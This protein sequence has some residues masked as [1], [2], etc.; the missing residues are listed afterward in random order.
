MTFFS[1]MME[2]AT[3]AIVISVLLIMMAVVMVLAL[4]AGII[5]L[6]FGA[7]STKQLFCDNPIKVS[8]NTLCNCTKHNSDHACMVMCITPK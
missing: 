4:F 7:T 3:S 2:P 6:R 1:I 8:S 5:A